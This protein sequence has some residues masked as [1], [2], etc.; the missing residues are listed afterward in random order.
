MLG[1]KLSVSV[2]HV[3][4]YLYFHFFFFTW[5][6]FSVRHSGAA[7]DALVRVGILI[8]VLVVFALS[9]MQRMVSCGGLR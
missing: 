7:A 6:L 1:H 9:F 5:K 3:L 8:K 2:H 4:C